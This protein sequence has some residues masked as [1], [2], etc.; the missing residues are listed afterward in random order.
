MFS[1]LAIPRIEKMSL[2]S[3]PFRS[4]NCPINAT[5]SAYV[6]IDPAGTVAACSHASNSERP[7][8]VVVLCKLALTGTALF[9]SGEGPAL[10]V[11][12]FLNAR[13]NF[14]AKEKRNFTE[15][16]AFLNSGSEQS[17]CQISSSLLPSTIS[18][19]GSEQTPS[20][21]Q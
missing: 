5:E 3:N 16:F 2:S 6:L 15:L 8:W 9:F 17:F 21:A 14:M 12:P 10:G 1:S 7:G 20:S 18:K 19:S 4:K 13:Y 11:S